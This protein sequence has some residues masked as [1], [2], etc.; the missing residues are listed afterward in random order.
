MITSSL[1]RQIAD[2]LRRLAT[3][4]EQEQAE[5]EGDERGGPEQDGQE[6]R[7]PQG[8]MDMA[9]H[10]RFQHREITRQQLKQDLTQRREDDLARG[11]GTR[12]IDDEAD[13]AGGDEEETDE[14]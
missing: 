6:H 4:P 13:E 9:R 2:R 8:G 12:A 10:R 14:T 3:E 11:D 5:D 7:I 1:L